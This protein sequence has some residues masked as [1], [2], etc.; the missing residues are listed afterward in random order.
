[1]IEGNKIEFFAFRLPSTRKSLEV[2]SF[3]CH[4]SSHWKKTSCGG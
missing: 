4:S 1:L 2:D 3:F